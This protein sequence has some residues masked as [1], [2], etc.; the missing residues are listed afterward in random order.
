MEVDD[1]A[2][3]LLMELVAI[4]GLLVMQVVGLAG[5][6]LMECNGLSGLW[7]ISGDRGDVCVCRACALY[8]VVFDFVI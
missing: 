3:L 7:C 8:F 5:L 2:G 4:A 6:L 1:I